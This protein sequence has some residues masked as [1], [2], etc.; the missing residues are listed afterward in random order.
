MEQERRQLRAEE[1]RNKMD[2]EAVDRARMDL[3]GG[4]RRLR[5]EERR[6]EEAGEAARREKQSV[7]E[8]KNRVRH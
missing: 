6:L 7:D 3:A 4:A 8:A 5:E 1:E 2:H